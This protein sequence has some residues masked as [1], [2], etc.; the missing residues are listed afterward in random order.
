MNAVFKSVTRTA[1]ALLVA[2]AASAPAL[3][4]DDATLD[5]RVLVAHGGRVVRE[6]EVLQ[7]ERLDL[8][9]LRHGGPLMF[10]VPLLST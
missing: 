10:A 4:H 1:L 9:L 5:Q 8:L 7:D 2:A 6:Q 3:A